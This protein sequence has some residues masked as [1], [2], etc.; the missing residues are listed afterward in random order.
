MRTEVLPVVVL[1]GSPRSR[2]RSYGEALR[3]TI[4]EVAARWKEVIAATHRID[5]DAY[6]ARFLAETRFTDAIERW[7]PELGEE[8]RGLAEGAALDEATALSLQLM[9][10]EW[11]YGRFVAGGHCTALGLAGR[12][13]RPTLLGQTMDLPRW[14]DG[15]QVVL[16]VKDHRSDLEAFVFTWAGLIGQMGINSAGLGVCVNTLMD[17]GHAADGLPM[18]C[19]ARGALARRSAAEAAEFL[20][21]IRHASGQNYL[22]GDPEG[23]AS[24]ECSAGE[25]ARFEPA[26][27][28]G[29]LWHT[30]HPFVN[31]DLREGG[32]ASEG[33][34]E[35]V[36]AL[37]DSQARGLALERRMSDAVWPGDLAAFKEALSSRDD[38]EHPIS[39]PLEAAST[40]ADF[41]TIGAVIHELGRDAATMHVTAGPPGDVAW[42][43]LRFEDQPDGA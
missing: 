28:P 37:R 7:A 26:G 22:I 31:A 29:C 34:A 1:E 43:T 12:D 41:C 24:Y 20:R 6:L 21:S 13:G 18:S 15:Y 10:E 2:G 36:L 35:D 33:R 3:R 8:I 30:N 11:W 27:R 9:D 25:K 5:P 32:A 23:V 38:P 40:P 19:V 4:H 14:H 16:R 42:R 17:L 39:R